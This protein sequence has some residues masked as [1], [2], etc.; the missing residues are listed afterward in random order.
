MQV[1]FNQVI[2]RSN[3]NSIKW[4]HENQEIL[5]MWVADMDFKA[6]ESVVAA[7]V[8]R[9]KH[10][11]YGYSEPD[12]AYF[13]AIINWQAK[14]NAWKVEQEWIAFSPGVVPAVN[15]IIRTLTNPGEKVLVQTPV[16]Y[17]FFN[18][19]AN[20]GCQMETNP[21]IFKDGKYY[22]DFED[23]EEKTAD[24]NLHMMILCSPHNP[25]GRVWTKEELIRVG[26]I[27]AKNEVFVIADEIH[28]DLIL[29]G[30]RHTP[31]ASISEAFAQN[32]ITCMA[33]SKT[34]N[35]AGLQTSFLVIPNEKIRNRYLHIVESNSLMTNTFGITG[36]VAAYNTGEKWLEQLIGYLESNLDFLNRFVKENMPEIQVIQPE[37]MYLVWMDFRALGLSKDQLEELMLKEA[38]IWLD[39]G[40]IFGCEGEGFE[41]INIACPRSILEDGLQRIAAAIKKT[42]E[43]GQYIS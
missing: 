42:R 36:L 7:L 3:T 1:D 37:G 35:L 8:E 32:S 5:P 14:R 25:V 18:A 38:K 40:Y 10:G 13:E 28:S 21:M 17:P 4:D 43:E 29:S 2:D 12:E 9:A 19:I 23:L 22:M 34:F 16:Y 33:P 26:E 41:R 27:C 24:P 30:N 6:P 11:I 20:N 15:M 31:F 39:E